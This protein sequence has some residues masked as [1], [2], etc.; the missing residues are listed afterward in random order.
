MG[1]RSVTL[2]GAG[3]GLLLEDEVVGACGTGRSVTTGSGSVWGWG[4]D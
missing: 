2:G 3:T 4:F 1:L